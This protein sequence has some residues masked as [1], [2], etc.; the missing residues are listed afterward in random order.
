M[1][2][3]ILTIYSV[4]L[5][6]S[7]NGQCINGIST[8]PNNPVNN[9]LLYGMDNPFLNSH[10]HLGWDGQGPLASIPINLGAGFNYLNGQG[11]IAMKNPYS[12]DNA[13]GYYSYLGSYNLDE[14]DNQ[15]IDGWELL[16]TNTGYF[17]NGDPLD[18]IPTTNPFGL[19]SSQY[20]LSHPEIP[21]IVT[22]NRYRG[23]VRVFI[24]L[25]GEFGNWDDIGVSFSYFR[26]KEEDPVG[27]LFRHMQPYD[28]SLDMPSKTI[29]MEA[30][31]PHPNNSSNWASFDFQVGYDPCTCDFPSKT[32]FKF[33][34]MDTVLY[35]FQGR[36][37][38]SD[39]DVFRLGDY[40][41][42]FLSM[43]DLSSSKSGSVIYNV[44]DDAM[45]DYQ[46]KLQQYKDDLAAYNSSQSQFKIDFLD[47]AKAALG[48]TSFG[49]V[50]GPV[51]GVMENLLLNKEDKALEGGKKDGTDSDSSTPISELGEAALKSAIKGATKGLVSEGWDFFSMS[52][53]DNSPTKPTPPVRPTVSMTE[54]I[55]N[56]RSENTVQTSLGTQMVP[57]TYPEAYDA[58]GIGSVNVTPFNYP[59]YNEVMGLYALL[60]KPKVRLY[61]HEDYDESID[62]T[63]FN[64][65]GEAI[66]VSR[67]QFMLDEP[68]EYFLNPALDIDY[69]KTKLYGSFQVT[70]NGETNDWDS[71]YNLGTNRIVTEKNLLDLM[72]ADNLSSYNP[73][74]GKVSYLAKL[75]YKSRPT[76][77]NSFGDN[78][79]VL[80]FRTTARADRNQTPDPIPYFWQPDLELDVQKIELKITADI[81]FNQIGS[82]G[83]Q[84]NTTQGFTYLLMEGGQVVDGQIIL[85]S[86]QGGVTPYTPSTINLG[87][88]TIDPNNQ[89]VTETIGNQIFIKAQKIIVDGVL[90]VQT[91]YELILLARGGVDVTTNGEIGSNVT[92]S[93][94]NAI[95]NTGPIVMKDQ[96]EVNTFCGNQVNGYK[97]NKVT[98]RALESIQTDIGQETEVHATFDK[99][100]RLYPN[101]SHEF[102]TVEVSLPTFETERIDIQ[103]ID[104]NGKVLN[105]YTTSGS[106]L[107]Q[108]QIETYDLAAGVYIV[109]IQ[110]GDSG[111]RKRLI[112]QH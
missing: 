11:I 86:D 61:Y 105:S 43:K 16:Y 7:L 5:A 69:E 67:L 63:S 41:E 44:V 88:M 103:L 26:N 81:Y 1:K 10:F 8:D 21:Y 76:E 98:K 50:V 68:L 74:T 2:N 30:E 84:V 80:E 106:G 89:Y 55:F 82:D 42:D 12:P 56:G 54:F 104:I 70:I 4:V 73:Q 71:R 92:I 23:I 9:Q 33:K 39:V 96:S 35:T 111:V 19:S 53:K 51:A 83:E 66:N 49:T 85:E 13:Q 38:T 94:Q 45:E 77:F 60:R 78:I 17:P 99:E 64:N 31:A 109:Q 14:L 29:R 57:G 48:G 15:F 75:E 95:F 62:F 27:G 101:P 6:I 20:A 65:T 40:S 90:N 3:S 32:K 46:R 79:Y 58:Q 59:A 52:I 36:A 97:A 100:V 87:T 91:G 110:V 22:Y 37:L 108:F 24:N 18:N 102:A 47:I 28:Q 34:A 107:Q 93:G 112:V 72:Y 25:L